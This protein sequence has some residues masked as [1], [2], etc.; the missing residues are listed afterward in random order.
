MSEHNRMPTSIVSYISGAQK[1]THLDG[2]GRLT[3]GTPQQ[4]FCALEQ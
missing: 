3:V 4:G 2:D 1:V